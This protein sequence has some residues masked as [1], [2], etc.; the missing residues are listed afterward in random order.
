MSAMIADLTVRKSITVSASPERA[1]EI[2]TEKIDTWWP[3]ATHSL[4]G[5]RAVTAVLEGR[6]GGRM[7]ERDA[8]GNEGYWGTITA[9][10]PPSRIVVS[11]NTGHE[12]PEPT[13]FEVRFLPDGEGTRV[14]L[15]HRGWERRDD[16]VEVSRGY[17]TGWDRV[18][19]QYAEAAAR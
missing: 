7:F 18:L 5:E 14:E 13:E 19:A 6:E 11:W 3:L 8:D 4:A 1:F 10:E 15:E 17:D 2:F 16:S 9:W 12:K